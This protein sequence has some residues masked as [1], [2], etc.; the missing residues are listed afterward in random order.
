[1]A[2]GPNSEQLGKARYQNMNPPPGRS[3]RPSL[4]IPP[5][6]RTIRIP[7]TPPPSQRRRN[8][9]SGFALSFGENVQASPIAP[10]PCCNGQLGPR[11]DS[12]SDGDYEQ[13]EGEE[14]EGPWAPSGKV[15]HCILRER[16]QAA[17]S[18]RQ[19]QVCTDVM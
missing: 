5:M 16:T 14:E 10:T 6:I 3:L 12:D 13:P 2:F 7:R 4:P 19:A 8:K 17:L 9:D 15:K 11:E 18:N 1:M